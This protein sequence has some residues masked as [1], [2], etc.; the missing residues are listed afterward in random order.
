VDL[1]HLLRRVRHGLAP[2]RVD[3]LF[4][5]NRVVGVQE[6][7]R[8]ERPLLARRDFHRHAIAQNL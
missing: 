3:E 6:Q 7:D 5:G 4:A 1:H 8:E 2:E